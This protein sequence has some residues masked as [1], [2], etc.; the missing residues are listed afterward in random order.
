M[1]NASQ[2]SGD[3][4]FIRVFQTF[5]CPIC[6]FFFFFYP[7]YASLALHAQDVKVKLGWV[8]VAR[9]QYPT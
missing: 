7:D 4:F 9:G 8:T 3:F 5:H 6:I 1:E 2:E